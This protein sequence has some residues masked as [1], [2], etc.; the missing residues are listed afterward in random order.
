MVLLASPE[1]AGSLA[2]VVKNAL[3]WVV[4][5][6][7]LSTKPVALISAGTSGGAHARA[8]LVRTLTWQGAHVLASVGI[9]APRTKSGADGAITDSTTLAMLDALAALLLRIP[10]MEAAE[11]LDRVH[12]VVA[13]A[14]VGPDH[15]A[16]LP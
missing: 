2:G 4:G 15:V 12:A 16:P 11:R 14:G 13:D 6:G 8:T 10:T 1:Y 5:S 7:E 9:E 3:D